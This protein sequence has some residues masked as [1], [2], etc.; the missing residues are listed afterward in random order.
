MKQSS[1][2]YSIQPLSRILSF[3]LL[4][5][6]LL[7]TGV[8]SADLLEVYAMAADMDPTIKIANDERNSTKEAVPLARSALLPQLNASAEYVSTQEE[9][10]A[11]PAFPPVPLQ[12]VT[13][14]VVREHGGEL[15]L[16]QSVLNL[17]SWFALGKANR[18]A[19][20]A[21]A[22]YEQ[23]E[24]DL[25]RRVAVAY[26]NVLSAEDTLAFTKAEK[27]AVA[28]Q[29]DQTEHQFKVG[30]VAITDYKESQARYD[31]TVADEINALNQLE[32]VK[33][34]LQEI[35][36][37]LPDMLI[38][39]K[40]KIPMEA[41]QPAN[42]K[43]WAKTAEQYNPAIQAATFQVEASRFDVNDAR[44]QYLPT[45]SMAG[46]YG[47]ARSGS[48]S[49]S[50]GNFEPN[51]LFSVNAN[52][53]LF[54]GGATQAGVRQA[55]YKALSAKDTLE[56]TKRRV[57]Y[58]T[59]TSFRNVMTSISE[60]H[61]LS[62]AVASGKVALEATQASYEVGTRTS[63]DLLNSISDLY[64]RQQQYAQA[65]YDYIINQLTLKQASGTLTYQDLELINDWLSNH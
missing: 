61:A 10:Y 63:V 9:G 17:G 57:I 30:V 32:N 65:R 58:D 18:I 2:T 33:E 6:L 16:Q 51:W 50:D 36:G 42:E 8:Y 23:N 1:H 35:T 64:Q 47:R 14:S 7:P 26:F 19:D 12:P 13:P 49:H 54:A 25:F 41:P 43:E 22:I 48:P 55:Q 56:Q 24:Q 46:T 60:V 28:K 27:E 29:L 59:N 38:P 5:A 3:K 37:T 62:Q 20:Q 15:S 44:A 34:A 4:F 31:K 21:D 53:N 40:T 39:L 45:L 52:M 11:A